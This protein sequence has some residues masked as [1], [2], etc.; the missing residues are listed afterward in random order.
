MTSIR[1]RGASPL[2]AAGFAAAL[3]GAACGPEQP[4][5]PSPGVEM[6]APTEEPGEAGQE[7]GELDELDTE[8]TEVPETEP[9]EEVAPPEE[10]DEAPDDETEP[11]EGEETTEASD[12]G[13]VGVVAV[14]DV[15]VGTHADF[16][17]VVFE[18]EGDGLAGW[19]VR[20]VDE[21][22]SQG[23]GEEVEVAGDAVLA[24]ALQNV[25]LPPDLPADIEIWEED[26]VEGPIGG[27]IAEVVND[28]IFEG[29]QLVFVGLDEE[30][31]FVIERFE[32]PQRVVI[33]IPHGS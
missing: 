8:P 10:T 27:L 20:Y 29:I 31:A 22:T 33:D 21:A 28:T 3:V 19:D 13:E 5:E 1:R 6:E 9:A 2:L 23:S 26:R 32:D 18:I 25:T 14:T 30:R 24:V 16:D 12:D 17:R 4:E 15:R 11:I 7:P